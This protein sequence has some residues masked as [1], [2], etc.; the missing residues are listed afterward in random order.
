MVLMYGAQQ[1]AQNHQNK[2]KTSRS[3]GVPS[4]LIDT[5]D[6]DRYQAEDGV[7]WTSTSRDTAE[8]WFWEL[9]VQNR[10][11][12]AKT[13][14]PPAA[15]PAHLSTRRTQTDRYQAKDGVKRTSTSRDTAESWF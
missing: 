3:P 5:Q 15:F 11:N 7:K 2:A 12:P 4:T 8:S 14:R 1:T 10:Q 6:T 13:S 9:K